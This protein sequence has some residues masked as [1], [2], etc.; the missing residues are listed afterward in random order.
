MFPLCNRD[1]VRKARE[2]HLIHRGN[3]LSP[4]GINR[5]DEAPRGGTHRTLPIRVCAAQRGRDSEA[6]D[7]ERF[8]TH[9]SS[10]CTLVAPFV[11]ACGAGIIGS[12]TI[13]DA[14]GSENVTFKMSSRFFTFVALIPIF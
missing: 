1:A 9:E 11:L 2:A 5:R 14:D 4:L 6:P 7:L 3:T 13:D 8:R 10:G 12:F